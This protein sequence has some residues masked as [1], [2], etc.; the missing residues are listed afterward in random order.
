M[1]RLLTL[2]SASL[3]AA[4]AAA[5]LQTAPAPTPASTNQAETPDLAAIN[6]EQ[7]AATRTYLA[8]IAKEAKRLDDRKS[9]PASIAPGIISSCGTQFS[10]AAE[11]FSRHYTTDDDL[12]I[13]DQVETTLRKEGS[14]F[15]IK[16]ILENRAKRRIRT[17]SE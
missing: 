11:A 8:C 12:Q 2:L 15:A 3:L 6:T 9:D 16:T 10:G 14:D 7:E 5:T 13:K 1:G 17:M 4:C